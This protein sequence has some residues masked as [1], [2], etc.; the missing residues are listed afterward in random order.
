M[1]LEA[2]KMPGP[3]EKW[4]AVSWGIAIFIIW[5][6]YIIVYYSILYKSIL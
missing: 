5:L 4:P 2:A 3:H 6:V 1:R